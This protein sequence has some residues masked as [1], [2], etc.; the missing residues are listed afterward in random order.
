MAVRSTW[1]PGL[2]DALLLIAVKESSEYICHH[3]ACN[4]ELAVR[5]YERSVYLLN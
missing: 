3:L 1:K 5:P 2:V 4:S